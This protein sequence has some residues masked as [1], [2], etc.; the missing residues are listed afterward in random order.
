ML[1]FRLAPE[2]SEKVSAWSVHVDSITVQNDGRAWA[3]LEKCAREWEKRCA[4]LTAG[5][6]EGIAEARRLYREFGVDPTRTRP[7]SEAL[8][9]RAL[10]GQS[11]Y[12]L[13]NV[14]DVGNW[15]SLEFLLPL[16]LYDRSR[17]VGDEALVRIG[18]EG[19]EYAGIRKG[20]V[21][22][23]GRL[24][25]VDAEGPFGS[26]TSDSL[27]CSI[28]ESC[29]EVSAIVFAPADIDPHR[30]E[31][32]GEALAQRLC[33]FAGGQRVRSGRVQRG[34]DSGAPV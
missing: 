30:L 16:G 12:R 32:A 20:P 34:G 31:R 21:H 4:G 24:C 17:I 19:E 22:L 3:E 15:V 28:T 6:V 18:G 13:S 10:K 33:D 7:S 25:V 27:R 9:R 5:Q 26:P 11:L 2:L 14:V 29:R 8:L 23:Q 1:K